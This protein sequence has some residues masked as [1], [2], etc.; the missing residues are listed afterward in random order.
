MDPIKPTLHI[1]DL[2]HPVGGLNFRSNWIRPYS[3][4]PRLITK[5]VTL[6]TSLAR[7]QSPA[8]RQLSGMRLSA[9]GT[10]LHE[11]GAEIAA[12]GEALERL[13]SGSYQEEQFVTATANELGGSALDLDEIPRCSEKELAHPACP[14]VLPQKDQPIR[15]V[16]ALS[17]LDGRTVFIPAIM[18]FLY[19]RYAHPGER[20]CVPISTGC[21]AHTS[22]EKVILSG[23]L[24]V[25]ERD[26]ISITWL[27]KLPLPRIEIDEI[28]ASMEPYW[29]ALRRGA[30]SIQPF[31][32]DATSDLGFPTVYGVQ[33]C[34]ANPHATTLVSCS[35]ALDPAEAVAKVIR[36]MAHVRV[37]FRKR[38][39]VPARWDEFTDIFHGAA[40]MARAEQAQAFGFLLESKAVRTLSALSQAA[41]HWQGSAPERLAAVVQR[42][43]SMRLN[44]YVVELSTDEALRSGMRAVRV[45]IPGLQPLSVHYRARYLGHNRLYQCPRALGYPVRGEADLNPWPQPFA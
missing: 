8:G 13:C 33:V 10:D 35:T 6:R 23:I 38:H 28:P 43:R 1:R 40:F 25:V 34:S 17:L 31:F 26:A 39:P 18:S 7:R 4:E 29:S 37:A 45:V 12:L 22:L 44:A 24:E 2:F 42:L 9:S 5:T 16:R 21:A 3:D 32:F 14:L 36:D 41:T 19:L 11:D 30:Q 20:I 15:W 27:Q